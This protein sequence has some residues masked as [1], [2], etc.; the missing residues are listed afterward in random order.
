MNFIRASDPD[1]QVAGDPRDGRQATA[2]EDGEAA[3]A[4]AD[5]ADE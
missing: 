5:R 2:D 3:L 4:V 1:A